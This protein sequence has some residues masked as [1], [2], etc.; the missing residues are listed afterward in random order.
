VI[1]QGTMQDGTVIP[2]QVD[3][4]GRLVA[5]GL[6]GPEGIQGVM[7]P[8][9]LSYPLPPNPMEGKVL[10]WD[11]GALAWLSMKVDG[12]APLDKLPGTGYI[13]SGYGNPYFFDIL[14]ADARLYTATS[15][16]P[17]WRCIGAGSSNQWVRRNPASGTNL[18]TRIR[19]D[20]R[21]F[22]DPQL[23]RTIGVN[24]AGTAATGCSLKGRL[25][26]VNRNQLGA[27]KT[28]TLSTTPT[29]EGFPATKG[30]R[31]LEFT[32]TD[33]GTTSWESTIYYVLIDGKTIGFGE[34]ATS[35]ATATPV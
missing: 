27:E 32:A 31:L 22:Y 18:W 35:A 30:A 10:G 16:Y 1:L 24:V 20:L 4:Q 7:G 15:T 6:P 14:P 9:G 21:S 25:L 13:P 3:A 26:D 34:L 8:P 33:N 19:F 11:N 23:A 29:T 5:E 17:G 12:S 28:F 2:V